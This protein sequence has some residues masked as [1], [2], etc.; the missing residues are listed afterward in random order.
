MQRAQR[1]G[2]AAPRLSASNSRTFANGMVAY[3]AK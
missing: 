3:K 1:G 2:N